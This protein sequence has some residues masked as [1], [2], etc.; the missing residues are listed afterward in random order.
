M[1]TTTD[2][3]ELKAAAA[4]QR[5]EAARDKLTPV[6]ENL[7]EQ[8]GLTSAQVRERVALD[9]VNVVSARVGTPR[10]TATAR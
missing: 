2:R 10:E 1:A 9:L 4:A 6:D 8:N 3:A 5:L 7:L